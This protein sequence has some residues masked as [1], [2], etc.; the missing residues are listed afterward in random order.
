MIEYYKEYM[1]DHYVVLKKLSEKLKELHTFFDNNKDNTS[2]FSTDEYQLHD[3]Y[4]ASSEYFLGL[5]PRNIV[6][7]SYVERM[8]DL[9]MAAYLTS[10]QDK[11]R[12]IDTQTN[13]FM[14]LRGAKSNVSQKETY[15]S[16]MFL[17]SFLEVLA[18]YSK[19]SRILQ[20]DLVSTLV[21]LLH[22]LI[23]IGNVETEMAIYNTLMD[24]KYLH[25]HGLFIKLKIVYLST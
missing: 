13:K 11:F 14:Y 1:W 23:C 17:T 15:F 21:E 10:V 2:V 3:S 5:Q 16:I 20:I 12:Y 22:E 24:Y 9:E 19:Q 4:K 18:E 6:L 25:L 7:Q 8:S